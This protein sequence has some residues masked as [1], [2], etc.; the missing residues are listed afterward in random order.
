MS[1]EEIV[2]RREDRLRELHLLGR[3]VPVAVLRQHLRQDEQAVER[4]P[5]LVR[6]VREELALVLGDEL[7]LLGLLLEAP[8]RELDLA[9]S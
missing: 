9:G 2:A 6:H 5:Q 7:E 4:R 3:E 8:A 1:C